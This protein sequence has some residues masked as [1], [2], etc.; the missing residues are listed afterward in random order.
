MT[1]KKIVYLIA[2][3]FAWKLKLIISF[4]L[5][6]LTK[7]EKRKDFW[8][9]IEAYVHNWVLLIN[10]LHNQLVSEDATIMYDTSADTW[11]T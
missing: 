3:H 5:V 8:L 11:T 1:K 10:I 9:I 6:T 2:S 4:I 7:N